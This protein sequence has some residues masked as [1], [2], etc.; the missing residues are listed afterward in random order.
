MQMIQLKKFGTVLISR[1]AGLEAFNAIRPQLNPDVSV[2]I[3]FDQVLTVTPSWLDEFLMQLTDYN[4]GKVELLPTKNAS[5]LATLPVLAAA[6][7]DFVASTV[8][9]ALKRMES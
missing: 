5:V 4:G 3:D 1:P 6:R 8:L 9:R 2:Q 7:K